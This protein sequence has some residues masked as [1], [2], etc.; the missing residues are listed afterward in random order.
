M[1]LPGQNEQDDIYC[2]VWI[3]LNCLHTPDRLS[4]SLLS[5]PGIASL[6][7][8]NGSLVCGSQFSN[9]SVVF[10]FLLLALSC[11]RRPA[12]WRG[13]TGEE[14][15]ERHSCLFTHWLVSSGYNQWTRSH[16]QRR[17]YVCLCSPDCVS[18]QSSNLKFR[19]RTSA[20]ELFEQEQCETLVGH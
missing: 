11:S 17:S 12:V 16:V 3:P 6:H 19:V 14:R 1:C 8:Q 10:E 13:E 15:T 4:G 7:L 5:T 9:H 18:S 2:R 20:P